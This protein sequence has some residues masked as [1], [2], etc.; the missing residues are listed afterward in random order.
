MKR[1]LCISALCLS[2]L[3]AP[4]A[5]EQADNNGKGL[6]ERGAE[7]FWE[8]LRQEMSPALEDLQEFAENFASEVGPSMRDFLARMGP[9][10]AEIAA[11]VEDWSRYELPEI[12]PNGDIIIRRK[13]DPEPDD[14]QENP[15]PEGNAI[16][17]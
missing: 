9:A 14:P 13:P 3:V 2:C 6:M 15:A 11:E 5:A 12:L 7:L 4:V 16:D 10:L 17:L 1:T 8:G